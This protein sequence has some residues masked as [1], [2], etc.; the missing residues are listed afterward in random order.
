[1]LANLKK[2]FTSTAVRHYFKVMAFAV[3]AVVLL[4]FWFSTPPEAI[5]YSAEVEEHVELEESS[6]A[7]SAPVRLRIPKIQVDA[8]FITP[9]GLNLDQT[10]EV[11]QVPEMVGWYKHGATPGEIGP[12]VILGHVDSKEGPAVFFYLG[13]LDKGDEVEITR[14]DGT[15]ATF[16]VTDKERVIQENF[17]SEKV[18]GAMD[19]PGL[20]LVTCTGIYDRGETRYTHNLIVYA[21]LKKE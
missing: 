11:P 3:L 1:M 10:V 18:Y 6:Y 19:H 7:R 17:P 16:V 13:Q 4:S 21:E 5:R 9:L 8:E 20:R 14:A 15:I 12:A 2:F